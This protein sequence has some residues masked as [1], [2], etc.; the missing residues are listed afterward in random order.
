MKTYHLLPG[1]GY[2]FASKRPGCKYLCG[3]TAS[4]SEPYRF[5]TWYLNNHGS[6]EN[7]CIQW[8]P[9][10][11]G[12]PRLALKI[13]AQTDLEGDDDD[14]MAIDVRNPCSEVTLGAIRKCE[15]E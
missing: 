12:D 10:C 2:E 15:L 7:G 6:D 13:L 3:L 5:D 9:E 14:W 1:T 8:C 11:I 4:S